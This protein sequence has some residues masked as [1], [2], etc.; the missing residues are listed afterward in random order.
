MPFLVARRR[1]AA[2]RLRDHRLYFRRQERG[3]PYV[4]AALHLGAYAAVGLAAVMAVYFVGDAAGLSDI[5]IAVLEV[6]LAVALASASSR[7]RAA[8]SARCCARAT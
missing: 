4:R 7:A 1:D 3:L 8:R 5:W 2:G 6:G